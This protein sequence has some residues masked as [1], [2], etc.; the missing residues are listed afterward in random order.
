MQPGEKPGRAEATREGG[1]ARALSWEVCPYSRPSGPSG[2][3]LHRY[4]LPHQ[5]SP[6][7]GAPFFLATLVAKSNG[8]SCFSALLVSK[9]IFN[10]S[11]GARL[12]TKEGQAVQGGRAKGGKLVEWGGTASHLGEANMADKGQKGPSTRLGSGAEMSGRTEGWQGGRPSRLTFLQR[13]KGDSRAEPP[14]AQAHQMWFVRL[15][16]QP[17]ACLDQVQGPFLQVVGVRDEHHE[18]LQARP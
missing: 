14:A 1:R 6:W 17:F 13:Q 15:H 8:L 16:F 11:P 2:P 4:L 9:L 10:R 18:R 12:S 3:P 7:N 5:A